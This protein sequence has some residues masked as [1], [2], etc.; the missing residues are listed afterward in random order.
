MKMSQQP[1]PTAKAR[2][3]HVLVSVFRS[4]LYMGVAAALSIAL[5][6]AEALSSKAT[7]QPDGLGHG[8]SLDE[9]VT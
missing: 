6:I 4:P 3:E 2:F 5:V 9:D 1:S 7:V 8:P